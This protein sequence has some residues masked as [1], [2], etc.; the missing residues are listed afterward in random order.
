M[1]YLENPTANLAP[2][3]GTW[4]L[5]PARTTVEFRTKGMWMLNVKGTAQASGGSGAVGDDGTVAGRVEIDMS[6]VSTG[7]KKRD[8]HLQTAD[9]LDTAKYPTMTFDVISARLTG[10]DR[11]EV[12]G[13]LAVHGQT[14][15]LTVP[16][17]IH[18]SANSVDVSAEFDIDRSQWN[19]TWSKMGAGL[20]NRVFVKAHFAKS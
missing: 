20:H 3:A 7:N 10:P 12:A 4:V 17:E 13:T 11:A 19:I 6:S 2:L 8:T 14:R 1:T 5:D 16:V 9:F 18:A 15:P